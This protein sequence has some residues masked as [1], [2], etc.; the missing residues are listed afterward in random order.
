MSDQ[1]RMVVRGRVQGV[2]FRYAT[3]RRAG[4]LGVAGWV[5]NRSDGSVEIVAQGAGDAL[6]ALEEWCHRG[7]AAARVTEVSCTTEPAAE[8]F[9]AFESRW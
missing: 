1:V 9:E 5:R 3:I 6:V 2:G 7:P 4:D 8:K